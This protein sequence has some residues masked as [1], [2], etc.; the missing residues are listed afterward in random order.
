[1]QSRRGSRISGKDQKSHAVDGVPEFLIPAE[2]AGL[3]R[4]SARTL[5]NWRSQGIGPKYQKIG[6][7]VVY[8]IEDVMGSGV[9]I[10]AQGRREP[11]R[12][13]ITVRP[14]P[15][16]KDRSQVDIQIQHPGDG[17]IIRRRL[18]AP[19][20]MDP[21]AAER[22]GG[23]QAKE[24]IRRLFAQGRPPEPKEEEGTK[25]QKTKTKKSA[26]P[27]MAELWDRYEIEVLQD[28][29]KTRPR[30]RETYT[31]LWR[32]VRDLI[33]DIPAEDWTREQSKELAKL[34]RGVGPRYANQATTL[35]ANLF[36]LGIG[37][38]LIE[39]AP[40]LLRRKTKVAKK[41]PAH[42]QEDL[43]RLLQAA[44]EVGDEAGEAMEL[45]VMLGLDAGMR[46][47]E[48][49]G[50]RWEDV[51]WA[52][53]LLIVQNQRPCKMPESEDYPVKYNEVGMITMTVR[54]RTALEI[55]RARALKG[56]FVLRSA[57]S[58]TPL[59]TN[60]VSD[61]IERIHER[62]GLEL[63]RGHFLRHCAASRLA[64]H[65]MAGVADAQDLLRHKHMST[66]DTYIRGIRGPNSSRRTAAIFDSLDTGETGTGL[67]PLGTSPVATPEDLD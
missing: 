35:V 3:L 34:F 42:N 49:A 4:I 5:A 19:A 11:T 64:R 32:R 30:T 50:L 45:M 23:L 59:D 36:K 60:L 18:S 54:L 61:R 27:T 2:A 66:T 1:M 65:P 28:E 53:N 26:A 48:V 10:R 47:G 20:G 7:R 12:M 44:R 52:N 33:A 62:A 31:K 58:G 57:K 16:D 17:S 8:H 13:T 43:A 6:G 41:V 14:Y 56:R 24:I 63:K 21:I 29:D 51:D 55:Q 25:P 46:P 22:W 67:A 15:R 37:E 9:E 39:E 40:R 38:E